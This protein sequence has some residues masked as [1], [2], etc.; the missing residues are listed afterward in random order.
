MMEIIHL[1]LLP[2]SVM[3]VASAFVNLWLIRQNRGQ[4]RQW[5]A[6]NDILLHLCVGAFLLRMWPLRL[7]H[8]MDIASDEAPEPEPRRRFWQRRTPKP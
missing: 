5:K 1:S 4:L 3:V 6:L 7:R 8:I 2:L